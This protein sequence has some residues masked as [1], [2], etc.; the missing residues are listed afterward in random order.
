METK[1]LL[2]LIAKDNRGSFD[3]FY[4]LYYDQVFRAAFYYLKNKA[5]CREVVSNVFFSVW[6]SRKKLID[7]QNIETYLYVAVRNEANRFLASGN[8]P[9]HMSLEDLSVQLEKPDEDSSPEDDLITCEMEEL[10]TQVVNELP[11]KCRTIFLMAR[12]EGLKTKQIAEMLAIKEST[13][14]VQMKIAVEKIVIALKPYFPDLT[15]LVLLVR[16]F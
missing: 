9:K 4:N 3:L 7:I 13:V 6:L 8:N 11:A 1:E 12:K 15:L 5:A 2:H 10:L 14:R 16:L